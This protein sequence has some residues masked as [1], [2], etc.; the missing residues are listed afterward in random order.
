MEY[1]LEK[2]E[3]IIQGSDLIL[4]GIG[5]E[6]EIG[7]AVLEESDI[8]NTF[9]DKVLR[10]GL[11][12]EN[13]EW[14]YPFMLYEAMSQ[15]KIALK[16]KMAYDFLYNMLSDKNY[17]IISMNMDDMLQ[18]SSFSNDKIVAPFGNYRRLQCDAACSEETYGAKETIISI[19][20]RIKDENELLANIERIKCEKCGADLTF[21]NVNATHYIETGYLNDWNKYTTWLQGTLNRKVCIL[22]L[23]VSLNVPSV[24]RFP[25]EKMGYLNQKSF[26]IRI[27]ELVPQLTPEIS[28]RGI[29]IHQNSVSFLSN[30]FVK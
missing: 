4:I 17:F 26:F 3:K 16:I 10:E 6:F 13:Y 1:S 14:L 18:C 22:E 15:S 23:G 20:N 19:N 29:S 12:E 7:M 30:G 11:N 28:E 9:S 27:N 8:Y 2:I 21:Q 25:F 5:E 24:I